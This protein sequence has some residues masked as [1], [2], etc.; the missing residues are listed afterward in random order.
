IDIEAMKQDPKNA[1]KP[2]EILEK[3]AEG[4]M[5]KFYEENT[6]LNQVVV[7]E[8][9]TIAEYLRKAAKDATVVA[10]KRFALGE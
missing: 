3:I 10:Y 9:E 6:L 2:E 5:R 4:K 8:K 1:T 7:G